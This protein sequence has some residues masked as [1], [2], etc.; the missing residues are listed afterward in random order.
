MIKNTLAAV[1]LCSVL[2]AFAAT[3]LVTDGS[4][5]SAG[6][7]AGSYATFTGSDL[8]GWIALSSIEVRNDL[9]GTAQDGSDFV[10]LDSTQNSSMATS[11]STVKGQLYELTFYYSGRAV[12]AA[13]NGAFPGGIV[14]GSSDGLSVTIAGTTVNL[15][16]PTNLSTDNEWTPYTATFI[17]SGKSMSLLFTAT[18]TDDSYGSSLDNVSVIAVPEPATMAMMAAGLLGLL[19]LGVRRRRGR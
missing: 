12:S 8:P 5:E 15:T 1:A 4:F 10:E 14:P 19:G 17:G 3:N 6:V 11:F 7:A 13:Y 16:S 9:V 2:P 18:G